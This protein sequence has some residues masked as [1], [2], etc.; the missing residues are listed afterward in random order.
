[1]MILT[2][3]QAAILPAFTWM[4]GTPALLF[5]GAAPIG[6]NFGGA[7]SRCFRR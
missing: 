5:L 6:F 3:S 7:P 1:M 2:A 4:A